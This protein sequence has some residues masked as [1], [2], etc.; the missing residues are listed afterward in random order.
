[1]AKPRVSRNSTDE[2][3]M[4]DSKYLELAKSGTASTSKKVNEATMLN[5]RRK[6][7]LAAR[8]RVLKC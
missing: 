3:V 1:M 6:L 7:H 2:E 4:A 5:E 8:K